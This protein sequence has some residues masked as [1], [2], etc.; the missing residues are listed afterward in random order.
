MA[1]FLFTGITKEKEIRHAFFQDADPLTIQRL[2]EMANDE[3]IEL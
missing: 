1:I 2:G 3:L